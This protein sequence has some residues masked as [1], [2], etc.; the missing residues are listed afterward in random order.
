MI[1]IINDEIK[2]NSSVNKL[3]SLAT[4]EEVTLTYPA[5]KCLCLLLDNAPQVISHQCF[6]EKVWNCAGTEVTTNTLYQNI[7]IIRRSLRELSTSS[8]VSGI[9]STVPRK[10]FKIHEE[11]N[12]ELIDNVKETTEQ[13]SSAHT[14]EKFPFSFSRLGLFI[15][16][17][18]FWLNVS[19][20][21]VAIYYIIYLTNI[22]HNDMSY[23]VKRLDVF[24]GYQ[25]HQTGQG[26]NIYYDKKYL[27]TAE[28]LNSAI[29]EMNKV[30]IDCKMQPYIY[31]STTNTISGFYALACSSQL[32]TESSGNCSSLSFKTDLKHE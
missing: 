6:F 3:V 30:N 15:H 2:F 1:Y 26:C 24:T 31:I 25:H 12:I 13:E 21:C 23:T 4:T 8:E 29:A 7:S 19:V 11:T 20:V 22:Y 17:K 18:F 14:T 27:H 10:G 5:G 28:M 16:S 9:I 32:N